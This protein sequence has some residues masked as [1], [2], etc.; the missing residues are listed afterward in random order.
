MKFF[1]FE[2]CLILEHVP[3]AYEGPYE[4]SAMNLFEKA[5]SQVFERVQNTPLKC[6]LSGCYMFVPYMSVAP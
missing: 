6:C 2:D 3:E 4:T 1:I 5:P